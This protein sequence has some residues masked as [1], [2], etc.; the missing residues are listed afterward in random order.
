MAVQMGSMP[1]FGEARGSK[2]CFM[3]PH[4]CPLD[5]SFQNSHYNSSAPRRLWRRKFLRVN[6]RTRQRT[7]GHPPRNRD[8]ESGARASHRTH[9][10]LGRRMTVCS[11]CCLLQ[12]NSGTSTVDRAPCAVTNHRQTRETE[13][14]KQREEAEEPAGCSAFVPN[15]HSRACHR[16]V[17]RLKVDV[18]SF[19][20]T[21]QELA[22][23]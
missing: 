11:S 4:S 19:T 1:S 8:F 16:R 9:F 13:R 10:H 12:T 23:V 2:W 22:A 17:H 21:H 5:R 20:K 7:L 3:S 14:A 18:K 6:G 15:L